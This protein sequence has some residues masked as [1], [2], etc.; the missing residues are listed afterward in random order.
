MHHVRLEA[1]QKGFANRLGDLPPQRVAGVDPDRPGSHPDADI[2]L[3]Q[4]RVESS[5]DRF[6]RVGKQAAEREQDFV[7]LAICGDRL[8]ERQRIAPNAAKSACALRALEI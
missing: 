7:V 3:R 1:R 6:D 5:A 8:G 4:K 2:V